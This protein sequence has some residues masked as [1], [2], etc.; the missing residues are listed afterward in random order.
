MTTVYAVDTCDLQY[1][2]EE[3]V[4]VLKHEIEKFNNGWFSTWNS[5]QPEQLN[6]APPTIIDP[7]DFFSS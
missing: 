6:F 5:Y 4:S 7:Q 2:D 3:L 1:E